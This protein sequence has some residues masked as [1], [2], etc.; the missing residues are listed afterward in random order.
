M[1]AYD[2]KG[3]GEVASVPIEFSRLISESMHFHCDMA[4]N[5]PVP[6]GYS[7]HWRIMPTAVVAVLLEGATLVAIEDQEPFLLNSGIGICIPAGV[8]HCF[9]HPTPGV[10]ASVHVDF[11]IFGQF[12]ILTLV[13]LPRVM[14]PA[15]TKR[16]VAINRA[17]ARNLNN[18]AA[19][20]ADLCA[21][22][23][24]GFDLL[25]VLVT[26]GTVTPAA[27]ERLRTAER[28]APCLRR[29]DQALASID[30][31][32][33][34]QILTISRSRLHALFQEAFGCSPMD[35]VRGRRLRRARELLA[36]T[37]HPIQ[38][39]AIL[40]GF[41]DPFHFSRVFRREHGRSPSEYRAI[42]AQR[43]L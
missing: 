1:T 10:A 3:D 9:S 4:M 21:R 42:M 35:L 36:G 34:C 14:P 27:M 17:L 22:Q 37:Q 15:A 33:M 20:L 11:R 29:I 43:M 18:P 6:Q 12:D 39:V 31:A 13:E 8:N 26:S 19:G 5:S 16:L 25:N 7:T 28:L 2:P 30:V 41:A 40:S 32:Q 24:L 38:E 23:S